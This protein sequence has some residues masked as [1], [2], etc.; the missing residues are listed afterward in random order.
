MCYLDE[1]ARSKK[2]QPETCFEC[3]GQGTIEE[4]GCEDCEGV[5]DQVPGSKPKTKTKHG[6]KL[7]YIKS[8][9][10][11]CGSTSYHLQNKEE[12]QECN[13]VGEVMSC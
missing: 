5:C 10:R 11:D 6:I 7:I 2:T 1:L 13:G 4:I 9:C 8:R 12:C 3:S